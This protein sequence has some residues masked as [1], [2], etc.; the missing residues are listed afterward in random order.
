MPRVARLTT[1]TTEVATRRSSRARAVVNYASQMAVK[2]HE[3]PIDPALESPL[4]D[5]EPEGSPEPLPPKKRRRK[6][7]ILE[8]VVYDIPPVE[9][10][11]S[12]FRGKNGANFHA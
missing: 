1:E 7:K 5:F 10:K 6:A 3:N 4:T 2:G 9:M 11:T 8:P 12:A